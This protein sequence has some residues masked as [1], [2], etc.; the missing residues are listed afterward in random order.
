LLRVIILAGHI[1]RDNSPDV[2]WTGVS[3]G[4]PEAPLTMWTE[5]ILFYAFFWVIPRR[6]NVIPV[7]QR[8]EQTDCSETLVY[9]IQ[10][11]GNYPKESIKYSEHGESL[12]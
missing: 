5:N 12:K 4:V 1:S 9:E 3:G 2:N 11:P 10:K 6:L 8:S 7:C